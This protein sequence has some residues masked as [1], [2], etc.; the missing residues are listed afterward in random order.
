[1]GSDAAE[2]GAN[3]PAERVP[4]VLDKNTALYS[5]HLYGGLG[6][7]FAFA[8]DGREIPFRVVGLLE[9][10]VLQG[11]LLIGESA[12][13]DDAWDKPRKRLSPG[14]KMASGL[15]GRSPG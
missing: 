7:E 15:S 14:R 9:N 2:N 12:S 10:S 13:S 3:A 11:S 4:V 8:Y 6:E 5:L 1:M